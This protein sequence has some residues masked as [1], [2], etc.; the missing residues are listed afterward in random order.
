MRA[1]WK[2][3]CRGEGAQAGI[4][5]KDGASKG[6]STT[7]A[8]ARGIGVSGGGDVVSLVVVVVTKCGSDRSNS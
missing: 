7:T 3:S 4:G 8:A 5:D 6:G 2:Q 1:K